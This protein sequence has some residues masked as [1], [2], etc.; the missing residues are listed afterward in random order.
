M[1][2]GSR[3]FKWVISRFLPSEDNGLQ[4]SMIIDMHYSKEIHR[5][6][7]CRVSELNSSLYISLTQ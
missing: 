6:E 1:S 3:R 7:K 4:Y 2:V 5:F